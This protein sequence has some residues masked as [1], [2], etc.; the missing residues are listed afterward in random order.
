MTHNNLALKLQNSVIQR[1]YPLNSR[2]IIL[3][4][5]LQGTD[6]TAQELHPFLYVHV[7]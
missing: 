1:N 4:K 5:A 6:I 2:V 7:H 3:E